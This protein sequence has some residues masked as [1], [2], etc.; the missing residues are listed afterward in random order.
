MTIA[1]IFLNI[2][3]VKFIKSKLRFLDDEKMK[4]KRYNLMKKDRID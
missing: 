1:D 2:L 3:E 4:A